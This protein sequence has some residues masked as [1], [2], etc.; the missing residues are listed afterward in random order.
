MDNTIVNFP[1]PRLATRDLLRALLTLRNESYAQSATVSTRGLP[2]AD[3]ARS[4]PYIQVRSDGR[5]RDSKLNGRATIRI[6][7]WHN[8]AG[9]AESLASLCEALLLSNNS[10]S[11]RGFSPVSGPMPVADPETGLPFSYFTITA[12]LRPFQLS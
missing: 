4:L 11:L 1:D 12:R 6:L 10:A 8:D 2:G 3:E 5:F 9:L 7:V